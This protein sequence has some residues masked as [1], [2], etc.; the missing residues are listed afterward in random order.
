M[1][2]S[3][4]IN[5][6]WYSTGRLVR[7]ERIGALLEVGDTQ[8]RIPE[9]TYSALNA[10][11]SFNDDSSDSLDDRIAKLAGLSNLLQQDSSDLL[12]LERSLK[13]LRISHATALSLD[14]KPRAD[15]L[16]F[17]PLLFGQEILDEVE[18]TGEQI[19][20]SAHL[21]NASTAR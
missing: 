20:D 13:D 7:G 11:D 19:T 14:L 9:P 1:D 12:D 17:D 16:D 18:D 5:D 8:Y 6:R 4:H 3:T 2:N 10:I 15:G 21:F